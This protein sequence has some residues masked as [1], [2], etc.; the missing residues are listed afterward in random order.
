MMCAKLSSFGYRIN[1][2]GRENLVDRLRDLI[3]VTALKI[4]LNRQ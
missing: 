4:Q 3:F 2:I 1:Q